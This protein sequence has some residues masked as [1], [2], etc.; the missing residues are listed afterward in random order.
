MSFSF[1]TIPTKLGTDW[2]L[3]NDNFRTADDSSSEAA[4]LAGRL[5]FWQAYAISHLKVF[6]ASGNV[7]N[8]TQACVGWQS[9]LQV[10]AVAQT[11]PSFHVVLDALNDLRLRSQFALVR[12]WFWSG[13]PNES[14]KALSLSLRLLQEISARHVDALNSKLTT[15]HDVPNDEAHLLMFSSMIFFEQGQFDKSCAQLEKLLNKPSQTAFT[16]LEIRFTLALILMKRFEKNCRT[17]CRELTLDD[18]ETNA[19]L[20]TATQLLKQ[21]YRVIEMWPAVGFYHGRLRKSDAKRLLETQQVGAFLLHH[22]A[23]KKGVDPNALKHDNSEKVLLQVKLSDYPFRVAS[24]RIEF[25]G[26][27]VYKTNKMATHLGKFSLHGLVAHLPPESGIQ[28]ELGIR[29]SLYTASLEKKLEQSQP[30]L[31]KEKTTMRSRLLDWDEWERK[32][33]ETAA[34]RFSKEAGRWNRRNETWSA[35]CFEIAKALEYSE[36][37]VFARLAAQEA[38]LHS[39]DRLHRATVSFLAARVALNT[40]RRNESALFVQQAHLEMPLKHPRLSRCL[41]IAN[42]TAVHRALSLSVSLSKQE[43]FV[44]RLERVQKLERLCLKAWRYDSLAARFCGD[45]FREALLLQRIADET[46][47]EC[48]D[49]FFFRSLLKAHVRAYVVN[50]WWHENLHLKCAYACVARLFDRFHTHQ[51]SWAAV[52]ASLKIHLEEK[53]TPKWTL[54]KKRTFS[55]KLLLLSWHHMPFLVCFEMAEVLYRYKNKGHSVSTLI[56]VYESLLGRL[57]GSQAHTL[58]YVS[59]E[60][61]IFFR[62]SFLHLAKVSQSEHSWRH[63]DAAMISI[64]EILE[65]RRNRNRVFTPESVLKKAKKILWPCSIQFPF[66]FTDSEVLF[67]RGYFAQLQEDMMQI[68]LE[69]RRC[70]RDYHPLHQDLMSLVTASAPPGELCGSDG[71]MLNSVRYRAENL[72]GLKIFVGSTHDVAISNVLLSQPFVAIRHEGNMTLTQA[73]PT[74]T[75]LSP[76]WEEDIEIPVFSSRASITINVMN[77]TRRHAQWQDADTIGYVSI[78]MHDLLAA[79]DGITEGKYYELTLVKAPIQRPSSESEGHRDKVARLFLSFQVI[80]KPQPMLPPS[81]KRTATWATQSGNWDLEDVRT[82]LHGDLQIFVSSRW[83]WSRFASMLKQDNDFFVAK[84]FFGKSVRLTSELQRRSSKIGIR[85]NTTDSLD[86]VRYLLGLSCC[87]RAILNGLTW[88][89]QAIPLLGQAEAILKRKATPHKREYCSL[90]DRATIEKQ[91]TV[92]RDLLADARATLRRIGPLEEALSRKTPATSEWVKLTN[93]QPS[94]GISTRYFNQD[95][96]EVFKSDWRVEPLEYEDMETVILEEQER[97]PHRIVIMNSDMKARVNFFRQELLRLHADDPFQWVAVFNDRIQEMQFFSPYSPEAYSSSRSS[98]YPSR[99]PT[100][101]MLADEF[102]L[103]HVL[104]VQD[105]FRKYRCRRQRQRRIRGTLMSVYLISRGLISTQQRILL[106]SLNC[107]RVVVVKAEHLRA[108]DLL[109]SDPFVVVALA[110]PLGEVVATGET[111]VRYNSLNPKWNEEFCFRYSF[112]EHEVQQQLAAASLNENSTRGCG[113]VLILK[114]LDYDVVSTRK[115]DGKKLNEG[116]KNKEYPDKEHY[117]AQQKYSGDFLGM[118]TIPIQNF[119]HGKHTTADLPLFDANEEDNSPRARGSL[120]VSIQWTHSIDKDEKVSNA[121]KLWA[122]GSGRGRALITKKAKDRSEL[123]VEAS[124]EI[125]Q[126]HKQ[127]EQLL[128]LLL[129]VANE[130]LDPMNRLQKRMENAQTKGKTAEE[131]KMLE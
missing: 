113:A 71:R 126:L 72:R 103:Y 59:Y 95:T 7:L 56:E 118:V 26:A 78:L 19:H 18:P 15:S 62:M 97:L 121:T 84:W 24:L 77:H 129:T 106:R 31:L 8:L 110:D 25:T 40:Q 124:R 36:A 98:K 22:S 119:I 48:G 20:R 131:A 88:G 90:S 39:K 33:N 5:Q 94:G 122:V 96:G 116:E 63:L 57:R 65:Q 28:M 51:E 101:V 29:K 80:V 70:W 74:W 107:V 52:L 50:K 27:E 41:F 37:W 12:C 76:S 92:V 42:L 68:P 47:F 82:Y 102:L 2:V 55:V 130:V 1:S 99:P 66:H 123:P 21:C 34:L 32:V 128:Q 127:M 83:I 53:L 23:E 58:T 86:I 91:L 125:D 38:L 81:A 61:L 60:E 6:E 11:W 109:T 16:D 43:P 93:R 85:L 9:Y 108:G 117:T 30:E 120:T 79:H 35:V 10:D 67:I 105:A 69:R 3:Q 49:T 46:F 89:E 64:N 73:P 45:S 17:S 75:N 114:V 87:Y 54:L 111:S 104:L 44:C 115:V 112:T 14:V 100:Y 13:K 4:R